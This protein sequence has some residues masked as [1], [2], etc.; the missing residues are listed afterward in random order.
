M[1]YLDT[2]ALLKLY[3]REEGSEVVQNHVIAQDEPLPIH[4]IQEMEFLNALRLKVYWGDFE[5]DAAEQQ[6]HYFKERMRKGLYYR[7]D[8]DRSALMSTFRDCSVFTAE[9]GCR[10]L[11]VLHV[12]TAMVLQADAFLTADERQASLADRVRLKR[13]PCP[14]LND[15]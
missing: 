3:I 15:V 10:T 7:P 2:S 8:L 1:L 13:L 12:A 9:T 5:N 6:I 11:D 14:V 4:E